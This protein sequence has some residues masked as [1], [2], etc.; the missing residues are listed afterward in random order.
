MCNIVTID[1]E[2]Y[3]IINRIS[4]KFYFICHYYSI[5]IMPAY[6]IYYIINKLLDEIELRENYIE[7]AKRY[8]TALHF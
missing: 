2:C 8:G 6:H 4:V 5:I 1:N 7:V 3:N